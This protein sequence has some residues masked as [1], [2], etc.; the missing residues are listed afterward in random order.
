MKLLPLTLAFLLFTAFLRAAP[1]ADPAA[2]AAA[3]NA[4]LLARDP[5]ALVALVHTDGL[6]AQDLKDAQPGLAGLIPPE[7]AEPAV[8][9]IDRL[10]DGIDLAAPRI[11]SGKRIEL[12]G[13]PAGLVRVAYKQGRSSIVSTIPY[14]LS[15]TGCLLAGTRVTD[16]G[17][18]GPH[19]RQLGF[20]FAEDYP[21]TPC[22]IT[23]RYN[24]SGVDLV[25]TFTS[26]SGVILGQHIDEF[27]ITGLP[28]TFKGRLILRV[29]QEEILR[30]EPIVGQT[31]FTYHR[32]AR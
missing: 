24:A 27:T 13:S 21:P 28:V 7:D 25:K 9:S 17:W 3:V 30:S 11:A 29:G 10:P 15:P 2:L 14:V 6:S 18:T 19:D 32:P 8:V 22:A 23:I 26:H 1:P 16:L 20:T 4:A 31:T 5:A 12:S